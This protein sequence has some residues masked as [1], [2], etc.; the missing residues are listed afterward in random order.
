M[1]LDVGRVDLSTEEPKIP[2][3]VSWSKAT[4]EEKNNLRIKLAEKLNNITLPKC[5]ECKDKKCQSV[6]H[7]VH[8]EDYT[9]QFLEAM[10]CAGKQCLPRQVEI[11][12]IQTRKFQYQ[13]TG[14]RT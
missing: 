11:K 6:T 2:S 8:M 9:V 7:A 5:L 10:E 12:E 14:M 4:D 13:K 3:Q 1:K